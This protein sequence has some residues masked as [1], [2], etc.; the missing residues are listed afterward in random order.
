MPTYT[1][2]VM[3]TGRKIYKVEGAKTEDQAK[4]IART[5][6]QENAPIDL[7]DESCIITEIKV[8]GGQNDG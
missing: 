2:E 3:T 1:V 7:V 5:R 6:H 8:T 4:E